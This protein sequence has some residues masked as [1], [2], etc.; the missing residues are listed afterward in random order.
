[1][2]C[3]MSPIPHLRTHHE[4]NPGFEEAIRVGN[5]RDGRVILFIQDPDANGSQEGVVAD[6]DGNIYGSLTA[7][8]ALRKYSLAK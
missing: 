8:M 6:S 4:H 1:M 5:V 7:G 3:C 2:T